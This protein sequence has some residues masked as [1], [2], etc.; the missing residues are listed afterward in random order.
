MNGYLKL[1]LKKKALIQ[2]MQGEMKELEVELK[3]L[4]TKKKMI[5]N[6]NAI[7]YIKLNDIQATDAQM[8]WFS[9]IIATSIFFIVLS[10]L[11][12][13]VFLKLNLSFAK[14]IL[15]LFLFNA[16]HIS[17]A[18]V[19]LQTVKRYYQKKRRNY[20]SEIDQILNEIAYL[21]EKREKCYQESY[22]LTKRRGM[23]LDTIYQEEK[24]VQEMSDIVVQSLIELDQEKK[25]D[26]F[27]SVI[28]SQIE[29]EISK[30]SNKIRDI[31]L[32]QKRVLKI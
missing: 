23:L 14:G 9:G 11:C 2:R 30:N 25:L 21:G 3:N 20:Q 1:I 10:F 4:E 17:L 28:D 13:S 16:C 6:K 26:L 5:E 24:M 29:Q 7:L 12:L 8:N 31:A 18:V 27:I 22:L 32:E 19:L 15:G